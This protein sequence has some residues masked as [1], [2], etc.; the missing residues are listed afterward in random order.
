M[1]GPFK[2]CNDFAKRLKFNSFVSIYSLCLLGFMVFDKKVLREVCNNS[3]C[4]TSAL[5]KN[6]MVGIK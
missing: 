5:G 2:T 1:A 6:E 3:Q 4:A